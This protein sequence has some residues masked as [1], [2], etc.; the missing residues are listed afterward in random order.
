MVTRAVGET[1]GRVAAE[2]P[3]TGDPRDAVVV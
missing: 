1:I 3:P 2:D